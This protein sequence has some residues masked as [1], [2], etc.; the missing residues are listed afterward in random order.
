M[1]EK[2][3]F[4]EKILT[5]VILSFFFSFGFWARSAI[6]TP[7]LDGLVLITT[8]CL[9]VLMVIVSVLLPRER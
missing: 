7:Q 4:D 9:G 6:N 5:I 2:T 8:I 3:T 1:S